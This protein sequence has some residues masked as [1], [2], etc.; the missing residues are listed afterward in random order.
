MSKNIEGVKL[1]SLQGPIQAAV[2]EYEQRSDGRFKFDSEAASQLQLTPEKSNSARSVSAVSYLGQEIGDMYVIA[3]KPGDGTGDESAH[4]LDDLVISGR[5]PR[6]AKIVPRAKTGIH[7]EVHMNLVTQKISDAHSEPELF[8]GTYDLVG[9]KRNLVERIGI[10]GVET[11]VVPSDE[12]QPAATLTVGY[13]SGGDTMTERFGDPHAIYS[14]APETIQVCA[15]LA[16]K[17]E[18]HAAFPGV[19]RRLHPQLPIELE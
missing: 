12:R 6:A 7:S 2:T 4:K 14:S 1:A 8:N 19:L 15:F 17:N 3:F 18:V 11:P 5:Y 16:V 10:L 13:Q 9:L